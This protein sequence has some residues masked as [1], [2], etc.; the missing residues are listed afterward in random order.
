MFQEAA[1]GIGQ[2]FLL[3]VPE[4]ATVE[5]GLIILK[6]IDIL[7]HPEP[8]WRDVVEHLGPEGRDGVF[9]LGGQALATSFGLRLRCF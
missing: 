6:T 3:P 9:N 2:H 5:R 8:E 1:V 7:F 4:F